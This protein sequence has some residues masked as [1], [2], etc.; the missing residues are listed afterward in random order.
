MSEPRLKVPVVLVLLLVLHTAVI[1]HL[2]VAGVAPDLMLLLAV[3]SGL[4]AGPE[5]GA[6]MGFVAGVAADLFLQTPLGL[7]ALVFSLVG[8]TVGSSQTGILRNSWW[9]PVLIAFAAS[10]AGEAAYALTGAVV[11]QTQL[12]TGRLGLVA[13]LVGL[14]NAALALPAQRVVRW[15]MTGHSPARVR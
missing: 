12:V 10:A 6:A 8:Y 15:A 4:A 1:G 7:S 5:A 9:I 14:M 3:T 11:G 13:L 2:R